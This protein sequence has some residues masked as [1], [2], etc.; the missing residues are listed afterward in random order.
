MAEYYYAVASLPSLS[1]EESSYHSPGSFLSFMEEQLTAEDLSYLK[2]A[3]IDPPGEFGDMPGAYLSYARFVVALRNVLAKERAARLAWELEE[4]LRLDDRG[5]TGTT[6][7]EAMARA[8]E[9]LNA[10]NP[11]RAEEALIRAQWA[12]LDELE[13]GRFFN[14]EKLLIYYLRLQLADRFG[15]MNQD[16]GVDS[17]EEQY[18]RLAEQFEGIEQSEQGNGEA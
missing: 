9:A 13:V 6:E 16:R 10:E 2:R 7:P 11:Y 8:R 12:L 17:F 18:S 15:T 4:H 5:E 1:L 3:T 14:V